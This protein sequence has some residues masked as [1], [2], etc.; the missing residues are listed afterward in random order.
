[1][2]T[3]KKLQNHNPSGYKLGQLRPRNLYEE[4]QAQG[5]GLGE[6][7]KEEEEGKWDGGTLGVGNGDRDGQPSKDGE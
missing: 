1:M 2:P 5:G 3:M 4:F 6:R 7:G